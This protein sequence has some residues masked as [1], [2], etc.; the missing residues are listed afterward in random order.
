MKISVKTAAAALAIIALAVFAWWWQQRAP[1]ASATSA[2]ATAVAGAPGA[3]SRVTV[4]VGKVER[5]RLVDDAQAVG[6]LRSNQAVTL[7]PEVSGR[8]QSINFRD[9]QRVQRGQLLVQLDD[10]L[11]QAQVRQ[12]KAQ[13]AL[14]QSQLRRNR[15]L[16]AQNFVSQNAVEQSAAALEVAQAQSALAQAQL[17]RMRITAPFDGVAG[18]RQV[19]VGDYVKDGADLVNI[20]DLSQ[21]WVDYSLPERYLARIEVGQDVEVI[22][23]ALADRRFKG[24]VHALEAQVDADGRALRVRARLDNRDGLLRPGMFARTRTVFGVRND[25]LVVPEEALV[26]DG[27]KQ[28]LIKV[29]EGPSG[30]VSQRLE[31]RLGVRV[32]G[33]VEILDGLAAGDLVVT[34]GQARLMREDHMPLRIVDIGAASKPV[35]GTASAVAP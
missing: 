23:D 35:A 1:R 32:P 21:I 34:A 22:L 4:E 27:G 18:L 11:Q 30:N 13:E 14:Q 17:A 28:Y 15:E 10:T 24:R 16:A 3:A 12:A 5:L 19:D 25:A 8:I 31:A 29:V 7:R 20:D 26:P 2:E 33:R 9:G 6:T